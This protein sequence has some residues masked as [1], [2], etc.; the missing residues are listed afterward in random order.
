MKCQVC[1]KEEA[2][3]NINGN[4]NGV[5]SS[6]YICHQCADTYDISPDD[7]QK[8]GEDDIMDKYKKITSLVQ[9]VATNYDSICVNC[10]CTESHF[11]KTGQLGCMACYD[12][13][14]APIL[15][16]LTDNDLMYLH[17]GN[18]P[19]VNLPN[20]LA[21]AL[22]NEDYEEAAKIHQLMIQN[23]SK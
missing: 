14:F 4:L 11:L 21:E 10:G 2:T 13:L 22:E 15:D 6:I 1:N 9:L 12:E 8:I 18:Q 3:I 20:A 16:Y 5:E 19:S 7:L 17:K 23:H